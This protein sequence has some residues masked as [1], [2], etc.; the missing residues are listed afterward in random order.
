MNARSQT[1]AVAIVLFSILG[2][3][4]STAHAQGTLFTYQ[5]R[6]NDG[7]APANGTNYG[8]VFY[9]YD[10]PT[11]GNL[12]GNEG[13]VSV[14]VSN[15]LFTVPLDFGG[16]FD[17][18]PRWLEISVQKNGGGFTTLAPRQQITPTPY[19][20]FA[21]TASNL[22]GSLPA[23]QLN[24]PIANGNLPASA[25]FAGTVTANYFSG[26]GAGVTNVNAATVGG[27]AA[28]NFWQVGGNNV[29]GGQFIGSTN[30]QPMEIWVDGERALRL[31]LADN[32]P[33]IVD[34]PN[35]IG[36]SLNNV[37]SS[38]RG[39]T[40]GGGGASEYQ[41]IVGPFPNVAL[42]GA[43]LS[44]IGGGVSNVVGAEYATVSGGAR[45][46]ATGTGS[47]V[48]GGG[49]LNIFNSGNKATGNYSAVGGGI[50]NQATSAYATVPGGSYNVANRN[51]SFAAGQQAQALNQGA[52]VW[53]DSQN[54][55]FYSTNDDSFNVRAQGGVRLV[56]SGAGMALD[57][58]VSLPTNVTFISSGYTSLHL[59]NVNFQGNCFLGIAAG[60]SSTA[61]AANTGVGNTALAYN[62][63]GADNSAMGFDALNQNRSGNANSGLGFNALLNNQTGN[64]N[65]AAGAQA[66]LSLT[67]GSGNIALG[68]LAGGNI[69]GSSNIDIGNIGVA[70]ENNAI[71]IGTPG[72]Q[73]TTY[74][75]GSLNGNGGGLTNLNAGNLASGTIPL[76]LLP[77]AVV[78]NNDSNVTLNGVLSVVNAGTAFTITPGQLNGVTSNN[79]VTLDIN[80]FHNKLGIWDN[81][82]VSDG[83]YANGLQIGGG[84]AVS[85]IQSGQAIMPSSS[86][87]ETNFTITFPTAF[88]SSPKILVTVANDPAWQGVNDTFVASVSSNSPSAFRVNVVRV[89]AATGWSQQLR[90]NWQAWQ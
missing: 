68:Y 69:T 70:G 84:T 38:A 51:Y 79:C 6:L 28:S 13:I 87:V 27:L 9:L 60:F 74:I 29:A 30:N 41:G 57:G 80:G 18:N 48:A 61:G 42:S 53:A 54:A 56:T 32:P 31:E 22:S 4:L 88:S 16:V 82:Y 65:T 47:V 59:D 26:S 50:G 71:R 15:G 25:T 34:M 3:Q 40:I 64:G 37:V 76:A 5:G 72:I 85:V 49:A 43:N 67:G 77:S 7:G 62:L 39:V 52:F 83:V 86:T 33:F 90:I 75:A 55:P 19:A 66:L 81:L 2:F 73:N 36:G 89:D 8:M 63:S 14:S 1:I 17:G 20:V 44:T 35:V 11:N 10:A 23:A 21:N 46:A 78:T 58:P 45:N 12:L 24:G